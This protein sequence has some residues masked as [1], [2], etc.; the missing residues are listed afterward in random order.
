MIWKTKVPKSGRRKYLVDKIVDSQTLSFDA[1]DRK[2]VSLD[3]APA[4]NLITQSHLNSQFAWCYISRA[5]V[6]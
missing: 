5:D 6:R 3:K 1:N 4:Q 2:T